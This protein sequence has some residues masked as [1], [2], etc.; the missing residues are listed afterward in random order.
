VAASGSSTAPV[1]WWLSLERGHGALGL[2]EAIFI[3]SVVSVTLLAWR[4][5]LLA[6]RDRVA[7]MPVSARA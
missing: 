6:R 3:A 4:F 2:F 5:H 1:G 7:R